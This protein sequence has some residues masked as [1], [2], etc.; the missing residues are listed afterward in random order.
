LIKFWLLDRGQYILQNTY[1]PPNPHSAKRIKNGNLL[2]HDDDDNNSSR[3]RNKLNIM[4]AKKPGGHFSTAAFDNMRSTGNCGISDLAVY[5]DSY[6]N[7]SRIYVGTSFGHVLQLKNFEDSMHAS[8]SI[9]T[10]GHHANTTDVAAHPQSSNM[11]ATTGLDCLLCLWQVDDQDAQLHMFVSLP[12]PGSCLALRSLLPT[13]TTSL[14]L[15]DHCC[16]GLTTGSL[17]LYDLTDLSLLSVLPNLS[18]QPF[19][20]IRYS[21]HGKY[22]AAGSHDC[23]IY[24]LDARN[25]TIYKPLRILRGHASYITNL[26]FSADSLLLQT[27][28]GGYEILYWNTDTGTQMNSTHDS[29]ESDTTWSEYTLTLGFS[30]MGI[31][32]QD[33]DGTDV[34]TVHRSHD[35]NLLVVGD[36]NGFVKLFNAPAICKW[37]AHRR[38][39][40]HSA[41]CIGARFLAD[42]QRVVTTGGRDAALLVWRLVKNQ[43]SKNHSHNVSSSTGEDLIFPP[44]AKPAWNT[45]CDLSSA[46]DIL[47]KLPKNNNSAFAFAC[48]TKKKDKM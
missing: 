32:E 18:Q 31:F 34:N 46:T 29:V 13:H 2:L 11:C 22:V 44:A 15:P 45:G 25:I 20:Q 39:L 30:V 17:A 33:S 42:D 9:L 19:S 1:C 12:G 24:L 43:N 21:P 3:T 16:V 10:A 47:R 28:C 37:A 36:D 5:T 48:T 41:H 7:P 8:F 14:N 38:Y 26:D 6:K 40:G 4:K 23:L 27:T 35:G